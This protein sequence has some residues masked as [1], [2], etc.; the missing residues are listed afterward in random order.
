MIEFLCPNSHRIRCSDDQAGQ[1][2]KC[3]KC[4]VK[5]IIP[6]EGGPD[7]V[8]TDAPVSQAKV[9]NMADS[10]I[11]LGTLEKQS[12]DDESSGAVF[13]P[14]KSTS[15]IKTSAATSARLTSGSSATAP[16]MTK[17]FIQMWA[18]KP[19]DAVLEI[20]LR[21]GEVYKPDLFAKKLSLQQQGVFAVKEMD[22]TYT[23]IIVSWDALSHIQIRK[24][25]DLP[26]GFG[27]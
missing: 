7:K 14:L 15:S 6:E 23:T 8:A 10:H 25:R 13:Q 20:I 17:L 18:E 21:N 22:G 24:L 12:D 19:K 4:G 5:F 11:A 3:P 27:D 1:K 26:A 9:N 16:S 2:A